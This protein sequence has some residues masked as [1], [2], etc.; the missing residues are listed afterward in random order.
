[1]DKNNRPINVTE[2]QSGSYLR[3]YK[4]PD[5]A[6]VIGYTHPVYGQAGVEAS[7]DDYLRGLQGNPTSLVLWNQLI[8]GTP[9]P[10]LDIRLSI[11]LT[12]QAEADRLLGSHRGAIILMNAQTGEIIVMASHPTFDPNELDEIGQALV[13]D[14][15]APLLNRATQGLYPIGTAIQ[16]LVLAEFGEG[17]PGATKLDQLYERLGFYEAPAINMP[18]SFDAQGNAGNLNVSPLQVS[19][20]AAVLS[21]HGVAPAPRI[22]TAV[23][24]REQGWVV[25]PALGQPREVTQPEAADEAAVSFNP[26]RDALL[27]LRRSGK[28]R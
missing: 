8:Y 28:Q 14:E 4:Y 19:L 2:G 5:L 21:N 27:E 24:T 23:N 26:R 9:P 6:P 3:V 22:A 16:P 15:N 12:L 7:L 25:L 13:R 1:M 18:V 10:G 17:E 20:A 11:D